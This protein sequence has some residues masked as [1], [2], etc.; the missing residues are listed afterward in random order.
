MADVELDGSKDSDQFATAVRK[1]P[2]KF[3][4][5]ENEVTEVCSNIEEPTWVVNFK[6]GVLS[7]FQNYFDKV[8]SKEYRREAD[9]SFKK[10]L[11]IIFL[12]RLTNS[13]H[14][15]NKLHLFSRRRGAFDSV[16]D[17]SVLSNS[18]DA[19]NVS[20]LGLCGRDICPKS[21]A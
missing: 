6:K 1:N 19:Q 14:N 15:K 21:S 11:E 3:G 13:N 20:C 18:A 16:T 4:I 8:H 12:A 7:V 2:L 5:Y 10:Y 9:V 17:S